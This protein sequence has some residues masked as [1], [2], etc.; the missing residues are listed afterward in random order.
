M[1]TDKPEKEKSEKAAQTE[2]AIT[3]KAVMEYLRK[4]PN[5]LAENP[6]LFTVLTPPGQE[7]GEGVVDFQRF[8]LG[9]LQK[10]IRQ[11]KGKYDGL[12]VSCRDN[13][14]TQ[15]LVHNSVLGLIRARNLE[16]LLEI[17]TIDLMALFDVDV[18]KLAME[19]EIAGYT[20][21]TYGE[22]NYSG[23]SFIEL[24]LS[25]AIFGTNGSVVLTEDTHKK[26]IPGF[27]QIFVDCSGLIRSSALLRLRL[28]DI[29][30]DVILAFGVRQANRFHAGQGFELLEFLARIVEFKLDQCLNDSELQKLI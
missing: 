9:N 5:F 18:V 17:I 28:E 29:G 24:G 10:D 13:M 7:F 6:D 30:R 20:E 8:A 27:E 23:I 4:H 14:S 26:P 1:A 3:K 25:D 16:Q 22:Q 11:L 21:S 12:V 2:P 15:N 19:S